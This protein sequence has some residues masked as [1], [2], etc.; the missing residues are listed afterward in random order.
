MTT[1][2]LPRVRDKT[3]IER[4]RPIAGLRHED[5]DR[6]GRCEHGG[7]NDED[8][9]FH[10]NLSWLVSRI[11]PKAPSKVISPLTNIAIFMTLF[12]RDFL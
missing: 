11:A 12:S 1:I 4:R 8:R 9:A 5:S 10:G 6:G 3:G 2:D 7:R